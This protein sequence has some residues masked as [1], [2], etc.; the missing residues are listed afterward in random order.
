[1]KLVSVSTLVARRVVISILAAFV[2]A[3]AFP[4]S[5]FAQSNAMVGTWKPN[6]AKSTSTA[7]PA[8][9][10]ATLN[11]QV[12]GANMTDT[13]EGVDALGVATR[14]VFMHIY[15][16]L[17]HA[18]TGTGAANSDASAYTRVNANTVIFTRMKAGKLVAVGTQAL[19]QDGKT[20]TI[21]TRGISAAG[22]PGNSVAVY[23]KQ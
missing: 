19:S 23:E 10:S 22:Q 9:R 4:H 11:F 20:L 21:T 5:G 7:G 18:T 16:G 8:P 14:G 3:I 12:A 1:M 13:T 2:L 6:L 17:P 15:D